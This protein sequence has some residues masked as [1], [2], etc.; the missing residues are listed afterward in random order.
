MEQLLQAAETAL[1]RQRNRY[2][3]DLERQVLELCLAGKSY[4]KMM[5]ETNRSQEQLKRIGSNLWKDL[6]F[7]LGERV[8]KNNIRGAL[9][10]YLESGKSD[11]CYCSSHHY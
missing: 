4:P 11:R 2:L 8:Q 7:P 6:S 3:T 10:R 5:S 9:R 1:Y